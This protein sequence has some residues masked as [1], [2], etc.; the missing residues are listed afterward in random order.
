MLF[1]IFA[2]GTTVPFEE[3]WLPEDAAHNNNVVGPPH[4]HVVD[5]DAQ[6]VRD[7]LADWVH[8]INPRH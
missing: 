1:T 8:A 5:D 4:H 3:D 7:T 2:R 6:R